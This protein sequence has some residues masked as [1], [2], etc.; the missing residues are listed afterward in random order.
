MAVSQDN[1]VVVT[2]VNN[3]PGWL[4][5][6]RYNN[7]D[8]RAIRLEVEVDGKKVVSVPIA[9]VDPKFS[10]VL[11]GTQVIYRTGIRLSEPARVVAVI[12]A[13]DM[14]A[15]PD[16]RNNR[17]RESLTPKQTTPPTTEPGKRVKRD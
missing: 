14:V 8:E 5:R 7:R 13:G 17:K 10:L 4:D 6:V 16:E 2:I 12:D 11:R 3:G 15:E 9:E 1:R